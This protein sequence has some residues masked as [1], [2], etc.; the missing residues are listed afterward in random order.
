MT[1]VSNAPAMPSER[2]RLLILALKNSGTRGLAAVTLAHERPCDAGGPLAQLLDERSDQL[3]TTAAQLLGR[4]GAVDR[5][6][7]ERLR[8][9]AQTD[10]N[11]I[12]RCHAAEAL[13][14]LNVMTDTAPDVRAR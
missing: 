9:A 13:Q 10:R 2:T 14:R 3:R 6:V 11:L 8:Q 4:L 7:L 12:V 1:I 5:A